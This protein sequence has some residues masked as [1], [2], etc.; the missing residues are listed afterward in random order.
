ML[1]RYILAAGHFMKKSMPKTK[2]GTPVI[3]LFGKVH[4]VE[5]IKP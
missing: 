4:K 5:V 2:L 3:N 1:A